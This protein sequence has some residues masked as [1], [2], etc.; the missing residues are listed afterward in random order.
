MKAVHQAAPAVLPGDAVTNQLVKW[1]AMLERAGFRSE[2]VCEHVHPELPR[3]VRKK[4]HRLDKDGR[5]ILDEGGVIL[6][7]AIAGEVTDAALEAPGPLALC[8]HNITPPD[9]LRGW[10]PTIADLCDQARHGLSRLRR[11][12][13]EV[14][15]APSEFNAEELRRAGVGEPT[16]VP[17]LLDIRSEPR[18][19]TNGAPRPV[20]L[21]VGRMVP[22][23][24]IDDVIK[25]FTLY[26]RHRRPDASL[27]LVGPDD[28]FVEYR[29]AVETLVAELGTK[30]VEWTG[31]VSDERRDAY[32]RRASAYLSM[33]V[34][35]GFGIPLLEALAHGV[36]VVARDAGA[37]RETLA[38]AGIVLDNGDDLAL[39]AE[40][41][42]E[43][44]SSLATRSALQAAGAARV[45]ELTPA[46]VSRQLLAALEPL[47]RQL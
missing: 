37:V 26:Q 4:V 13:F 42:H 20:I 7:Y 14:V 17:Y 6:H 19:T 2:I 24:R 36:P 10:N 41:L 29:K 40:A 5:A 44:V 12:Q 21:H 18:P 3:E 30:N 35:E 33:S 11:R 1:S 27:V 39:Y 16:I 25:V 22:N 45:A 43:V 31:R 32:Y 34:H 23:K 9:L 15:V 8:Y 46:A 47:L 38:G 28:S